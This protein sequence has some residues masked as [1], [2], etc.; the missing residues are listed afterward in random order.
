MV[1]ENSHT[2][3]PVIQHPRDLTLALYRGEPTQR[4]TVLK[5]HSV[6]VGRWC[7]HL[8]IVG[9]SH[10]AIIS[11]DGVPVFAETFSCA[12]TAD[13]NHD[14]QFTFEDLQPLHHTQPGYGVQVAFRTP[15]WQLPTLQAEN[16]LEYRFPVTYGQHPLTRAQWHVADGCLRWWTLHVYPLQNDTIHVYTQS[17][18][19]QEDITP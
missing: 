14:Q 8:H 5:S 9:E 11:R 7:A 19:H 2:L 6:Q 12:P 1:N 18:Y 10:A 3:A 15:A 17:H 4:L 16:T 13:Q